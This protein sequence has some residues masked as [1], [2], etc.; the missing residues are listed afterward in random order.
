MNVNHN[1]YE[2]KMILK[3]EPTSYLT[4]NTECGVVYL[5]Q[6]ECEPITLYP[7]GAECFVTDATK[8]GLS[9][10]SIFLTVTGGTPPYLIIWN[11]GNIGPYIN[12]LA[13]GTYTATVVDYY[14][15]FSSTTTC[16]V[17]QPTLPPAPTPTPTPSPLPNTIDFCLQLKLKN[18][19]ITNL[20]FNPNGSFNGQYAWADD[21]LVY[22]IY[23]DGSKWVLDSWNCYTVIN[24][25]PVSPPLTGWSILGT[26]GSV[27]GYLGSC[28]TSS[29]LQMKVMSNDP[30]KGSD[31]NIVITASDGNPPYLYSIDGGTSYQTSPI[32]KGLKSGIYSVQTQDSSTDTVYDSITLKNPPASTTYSVS[33]KTVSRILSYT[34]TTYSVEYTTTVEVYPTLPSGVTI[35]F[36]L[37]HTNDS[38]VSPSITSS[39]ISTS[40]VLTKN[41]VVIPQTTTITT[42][43]TVNPLVLCGLQ[44]VYQTSESDTWLSQS[45][46]NTDTLYIT[47][48]TT[49]I[50]NTNDICYLSNSNDTYSIYN[51]TILGCSPCNV[52]IT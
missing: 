50:R 20:H 16:T 22:S 49:K 31:G 36:D 1:N 38:E 4:A 15:D 46:I 5:L 33:L 41:M 23:W 30:I 19:T 35:N 24:N 52:I 7:L 8:I 25:S 32:F 2:K 43:Q 14:G 51:V 39:T 45:L 40:S 48:T 6:N 47:T 21:T 18:C 29:P 11:N 44:T 26:T 28:I 37:I 12:N 10:G 27:T 34:L 13:A 42:G 9:D 17:L 3:N